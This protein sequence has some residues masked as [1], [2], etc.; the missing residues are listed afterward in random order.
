MGAKKAEL[1]EVGVGTFTFRVECLT[2]KPRYFRVPFG[3]L[4]RSRFGRRD[5]VVASVRGSG[6]FARVAFADGGRKTELSSLA[7]DYD[8]AAYQLEGAP[9]LPERA[10]PR[11][12]RD[13][14]VAVADTIPPP[15]P[16]APV[17]EPGLALATLSFDGD[18]LEVVELDGT[19]WVS[20]PS[21]LR[22]F[23]KRADHAKALLDGWARTTTARLSTPRQTGSARGNAREVTLVHASNVPLVIARL[24]GRG[25]DPATK[26]KHARYLQHVDGVLAD[27]FGVPRWRGAAANSRAVAPGLDPVLAELLRGQQA[28]AGQLAG[29]VVEVNSKVEQIAGEVAELRR[30]LSGIPGRLPAAPALPMPDPGRA[31]RL[32]EGAVVADPPP[33]FVSMREVARRFGL[34]TSGEGSRIV[35]VV[36]DQLELDAVEGA[37]ATCDVVIGGDVKRAQRRFGPEAVR[38]LRLPL[39]AAA[40]TMEA[41][42]YTAAAGRLRA[43][44]RARRAK[45]YVLG[46][47]LDAAAAAVA[48]PRAEEPRQATLPG[49]GVH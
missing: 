19:G 25:M 16:S 12:E 20:L 13:E 43:T 2:K 1:V 26:E 38:R 23:G 40:R 47:M 4:L 49:T 22:P 39:T 32:V 9:P 21:L 42:G 11:E 29:R 10:E 44:E 30:E 46:Q 45:G 27:H 41:L 15:P 7:Y 35:S 5:R 18:E 17:Q 8:L 14:D 34:P 6:H 31:R 48:P 24:D 28:I 33:G 3:T 36:A 37:T